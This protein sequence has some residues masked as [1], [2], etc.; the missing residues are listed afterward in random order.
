MKTTIEV[1]NEIQEKFSFLELAEEYKGA[2]EKI[3]IRCKNCGYE[4]K[5][6]PYAV[7][8]SKHGC[9]K[10][11]VAKSNFEKQKTKFIKKL[12]ISKYEFVDFISPKEVIVKCKTCGNI[13]HTTPSNIYRYGCKNCSSKA[14]G[15]KRRKTTEQFIEEARKIHGDRY[16]YSKVEYITDKDPVII[17]CP[18][19]GEFTQTP[20]KHLSGHGC[21]KCAGREWTVQD[22]IIEARK[23]HGDKYDYSKVEFEKGHKNSKKLTIIC[24][25]HG[26]FQ[27]EAWSH[28]G[29][30]CGCPK[31][32]ESKGEKLVSN[33]LKSLNINYNS[34]Y[35]IKNPY[36]SHNFVLDFYI[37][38]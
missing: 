9:K 17:I 27:Q 13:R 4:W 10:C 26:E 5:A 3:L 6:V 14:F 30:K 33:I 28:L 35:R 12:D 38:M 22:F 36:D 7:K 23:I 34:Q 18:I 11:R 1:Q 21:H 37:E 32:N 24:P 2:N 25:K 8:I 19:H 16:D 29:L 15:L 20:V 31:C